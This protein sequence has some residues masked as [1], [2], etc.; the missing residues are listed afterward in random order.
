MVRY[1]STT[2][3]S[4]LFYLRLVLFA[5]RR[6]L[7]FFLARAFFGEAGAFFFQVIRGRGIIDNRDFIVVRC[8][9]LGL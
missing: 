5:Y 1:R 6:R 2:R 3:A 9:F 8:F 4:G 7:T